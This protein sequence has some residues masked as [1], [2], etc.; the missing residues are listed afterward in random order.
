MIDFRKIFQSNLIR[1]IILVLVLQLALSSQR[2]LSV[3][4]YSE[5]V[6]LKRNQIKLLYCMKNIFEFTSCMNINLNHISVERRIYESFKINF[7]MK[8]HYYK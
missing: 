6:Q 3:S 8:I 7:L 5:E 4:F 1:I 2:N